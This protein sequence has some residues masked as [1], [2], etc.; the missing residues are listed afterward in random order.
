M[1][2]RVE[3]RQMPG[4][5]KLLLMGAISAALFALL[6]VLAA[7]LEEKLLFLQGGKFPAAKLCLT[8]SAVVCGVLCTIG[9]E[10]RRF[11]RALIGESMLLAVVTVILLA[12]DGD[13]F[14]IRFILNILCLAFGAFAGTLLGSQGKKRRRKRR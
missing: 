11:V 2:K 3:T 10:G 8:L 6:L 5:G 9:Q 13:L 14:G 7:M 1:S 12:A 4:V